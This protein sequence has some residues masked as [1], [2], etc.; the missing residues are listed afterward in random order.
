MA[1]KVILPPGISTTV[2][3]G[4]RFLIGR[5]SQAELFSL[6]DKEGH[7]VCIAL[8]KYGT[9]IFTSFEGYREFVDFYL[10][11]RGKRCFYTIDRSSTSKVDNSLLHFDIEWYTDEPDKTYAAKIAK[12]C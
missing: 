5:G 4:L 12:I 7:R 3:E 2:V 9:R 1:K 6:A 8:E 10:K 11:Y